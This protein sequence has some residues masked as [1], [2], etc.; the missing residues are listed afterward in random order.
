MYLTDSSQSGNHPGEACQDY[1]NEPC[2]GHNNWE[3][4]HPKVDT[5]ENW[6]DLWRINQTGPNAFLPLYVKSYSI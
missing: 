5:I 2:I 1:K 3:F 6:A 4:K